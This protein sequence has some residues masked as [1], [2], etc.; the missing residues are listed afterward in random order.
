MMSAL[1]NMQ[2]VPTKVMSLPQLPLIFSLPRNLVTSENMMD[3]NKDVGDTSTHC[4]N[5]ESNILWKYVDETQTCN[6]KPREDIVL[7]WPGVEV[8][9]HDLCT[10]ITIHLFCNSQN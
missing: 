9:N 1:F 7:L 4:S 5:M 3:S 2:N 10:F 6:Q 8:N